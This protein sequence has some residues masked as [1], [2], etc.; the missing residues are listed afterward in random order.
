LVEIAGQCWFK[1][2][3]KTT[4]KNN[5][6]AISFSTYNYPDG[7]I[8]NVANHGYLDPGGLAIE[9]KI[10]PIGWH[11]P[12]DC[13]WK[14]LER[15]LGMPVQEL[16]VFGIRGSQQNIGGKLK[17][18]NLWNPPLSNANNTA[19]LSIIPS[20]TSGDFLGSVGIYLSSTTDYLTGWQTINRTF[21][22]Q[23]S[24]VTREANYFSASVRC[25][26]D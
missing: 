25:I 20:G 7:I 5:G 3:L 17:S 23:H 14:Y 1:E 22:P 11:V 15:Q 10:C 2:N 12:S 19:L 21:Y 26:K 13:E 9:N 6:T 4:S 18:N 16:N 24:G 8:E